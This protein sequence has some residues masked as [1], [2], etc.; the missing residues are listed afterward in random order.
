MNN[1][2]CELFLNFIGSAY[3]VK[4]LRSTFIAN[5]VFNNFLY[6]HYV[7]HCYS[8]CHTKDIFVTKDFENIVDESHCFRCWGSVV[9]PPNL[10]FTSGQLLT[11]EQNHLYHLNYVPRLYSV[12][13]FSSVP[14]CGSCK[15]RQVLSC[16]LHIEYQEIVTY[17]L[18][19][20]SVI[21]AWV[22]CAFV[23]ALALLILY[24]TQTLVTNNA[25]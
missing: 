6:L 23:F 20:A 2:S 17:K 24:D 11:R 1:F 10:H 9:C 13:C 8:L 5:C 14:R 3:E 12:I 16:S 22:S 19:V 15:C 4:D 25:R 18:D 7:E 21:S